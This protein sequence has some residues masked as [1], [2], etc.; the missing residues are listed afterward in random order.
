MHKWKRGD[1]VDSRMCMTRHQHVDVHLTCDGTQCIEISRRD[2]LVAVYDTDTDR[3]MY[4]RHRGW[5]AGVLC[6]RGPRVSMRVVPRRASY[7]RSERRGVPHRSLLSRR[8]RRTPLCVGIRRSLGHRRCLYIISV[9][10][11]LG[12]G[13]SEIWRE[14]RVHDEGCEGR[15]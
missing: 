5:K 14:D 1:R 10:S 2:T 3:C 4:H 15:R 11:F 12:L 9:G 6:K 13:V 7:D 8:T